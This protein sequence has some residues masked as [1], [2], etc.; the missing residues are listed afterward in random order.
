MF[1]TTIAAAISF[2]ALIYW[3]SL[4]KPIPGI[5]HDPA[6]VKRPFGDLF[7]FIAH[8]K[9][10]GEVRRWYP[11]KIRKLNSPILQVSIKP[12]AK[13]IVLMTYYF[14][15][16]RNMSARIELCTLSGILFPSRW[17]LS[18]RGTRLE[19]VAGINAGCHDDQFSQ[20]VNSIVLDIVACTDF[21]DRTVC[22]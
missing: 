22:L 6:T 21:F 17:S 13:P 16:T 14:L 12:F 19:R 15:D 4:P 10:H 8:K 7:E 3:L 11:T 18:R 2:I 9:Q 5:P 1:E 20:T